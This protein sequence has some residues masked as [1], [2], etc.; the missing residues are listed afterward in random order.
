MST[1]FSPDQVATDQKYLLVRDDPRFYEQRLFL[2]S[3]WTKFSPFADPNF[4]SEL[5]VC[6]QARFWEMYLA[7]ALLEMGLN[8]IPRKSVNGPDLLIVN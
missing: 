8:L 2:E 5:A 1:L 4:K 3:L 7:C 6:F